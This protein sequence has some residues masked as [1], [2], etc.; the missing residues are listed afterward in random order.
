[1][2][3]PGAESQEFRKLHVPSEPLI[4]FNIWDPGS[5]KAVGDAGAK[6]LA[7]RA[8]P[9]RNRMGTRTVNIHSLLRHGKPSPDRRGD[10]PARNSGFRERLRRHT[11]KVGETIGLALKAGA[12][13]CNLEDSFPREWFSS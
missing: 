11:K 12:I 8:G 13:G 2:T 10:G 1:M 6:A 4:L 7:T 3:K 9:F 5:A